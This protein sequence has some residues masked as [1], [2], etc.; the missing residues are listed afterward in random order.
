MLTLRHVPALEFV[1]DRSLDYG[2]R[3]DGI[4]NRL[5]LDSVPGKESEDDSEREP[6]DE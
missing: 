1:Q 4:L 6:T 5:A 3:I 2:E